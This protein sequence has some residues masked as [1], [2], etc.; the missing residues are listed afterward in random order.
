MDGLLK[1]LGGLGRNRTTDTRIFNPLL[2]Q[3]S[4]Q[5][6]RSETIA[7][8]SPQTAGF[9]AKQVWRRVEVATV[10]RRRL[11][12]AAPATVLRA[13]PRRKTGPRVTPPQQRMMLAAH[14]N[15]MPLVARM[16]RL[17]SGS[18]PSRWA[19]AMVNRESAGPMWPNSI[20]DT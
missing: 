3:L 4:Y 11:A 1:N 13:M 6:T 7:A 9:A 17:P 5:A 16:A 15:P 10:L 12:S 2:Y 8:C 19:M 20:K 14:E 18:S